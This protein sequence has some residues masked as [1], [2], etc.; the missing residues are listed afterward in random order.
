VPAQR[1][2]EHRHHVGL[3]LLVVRFERND[4]ARG[5]VEHAVDAQRHAL[6]ANQNRWPVAHVAV[7]QRTG[8][9]GLPAQARCR[10]TAIARRD[11]V[12]A[13]L[14]VEP[15]QGR[16]AERGFVQTPI[17]DERAQDQRHACRGILAAD[18]Q[19]QIALWC[20]QGFGAAAVF[21]PLRLERLQARAL[22]RVVPALERRHREGARMLS[23][24]RA[25]ALLAQRA[26][27]F[28]ELTALQI[29]PAQRAHNLAAENRHGF[30]VVFGS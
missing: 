4:V 20:E 13:R 19:E 12:E 10:A 29:A 14:D 27:R 17:E 15:A 8:L 5:I 22:A 30:V 7:P 25:K 16:G 21:A 9:L 28:F 3:A 1:A 26:Q 24:R 6:V 2:Q 11:A 18:V 23:A